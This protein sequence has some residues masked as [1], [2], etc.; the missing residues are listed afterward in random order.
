MQI[1]VNKFENRFTFKIKNGYSLELLT[2]ETIKL[3][4][5]TK[6]KMTK[7]KNGENI[8][9]PEIT[10]VVLVHRRHLISSLETQKLSPFSEVS[11]V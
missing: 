2:P 8:P 7:D 5:S 6:N 10:K 3:L 11:N 4:E 1:Y 9:H